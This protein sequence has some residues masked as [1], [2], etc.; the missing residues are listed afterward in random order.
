MISWPRGH[1]S[2]YLELCIMY[3]LPFS[4]KLSVLRLELDNLLACPVEINWGHLGLE[5]SMCV[6]GAIDVKLPLIYN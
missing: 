4:K 6:V 1:P 3:L 5:S 2:N